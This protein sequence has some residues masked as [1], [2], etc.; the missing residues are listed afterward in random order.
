MKKNFLRLTVG[1]L[2]IACVTLAS[3]S[4]GVIL[5]MAAETFDGVSILDMLKG[6]DVEEDTMAGSIVGGNCEL[7]YLDNDGQWQISDQKAGL[8]NVETWEPGY[9]VTHVF[10]VVN[11][12]EATALYRVSVSG[13]FTELANVIGVYSRDGEELP[14]NSELEGYTD[15]GKLSN[16]KS[17]FSTGTIIKEKVSDGNIISI[18]PG[19][20][21]L[22]TTNQFKSIAPGETAYFTMV[23]KMDETAGNEYQGMKLGQVNVSAITMSYAIT[24]K[25]VDGEVDYETKHYYYATTDDAAIYKSEVN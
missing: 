17:S 25:P 12:S 23:L 18:A 13:D 16:M 7:Y 1:V 24:T 22:I 11:V 10:K 8:F 6:N 20:S 14:D 4:C 2:L 19:E 15:L 21:T 3:T 9:Y 5:D